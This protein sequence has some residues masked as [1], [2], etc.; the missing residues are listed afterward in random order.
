AGR[1]SMFW[2]RWFP[3]SHRWARLWIWLRCP[4]RREPRGETASFRRPDCWRRGRRWGPG[5]DFV[6]PGPEILRFLELRTGPLHKLYVSLNPPYGAIV[7]SRDF[8]RPECRAHTCA[9]IFFGSG[10]SLLGFCQWLEQTQ[11]SI[12]LH[13][14]LWVYPI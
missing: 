1:T 3:S 12:A 11:G 8:T 5:V 9:M 6:V 2:R 7:A 4:Y 10:M 13:E 14:S